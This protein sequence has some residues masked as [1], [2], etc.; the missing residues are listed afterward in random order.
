MQYNTVKKQLK[1]VRKNALISVDMDSILSIIVFM[2]GGSMWVYK[3]VVEKLRD[4]GYSTYK[5]KETNVL[6]QGTIQS[7][8]DGKSLSIKTLDRIC[9]LLHCKLEDIVE[10]VPDEEIPFTDR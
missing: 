4:A 6:A 2:G 5:I 10:I 7:L 8:R 9:Q 1:T 3:N